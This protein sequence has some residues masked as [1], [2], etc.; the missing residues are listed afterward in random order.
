MRYCCKCISPLC[1]K[2]V[3]YYGMFTSICEL[4]LEENEPIEISMEYPENDKDY[5]EFLSTLIWLE[6]N[7]FI[8]TTES[9]QDLTKI[10]PQ[11]LRLNPD[12]ADLEFCKCVTIGQKR[13]HR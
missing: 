6:K 13:V 3:K 10:I 11:G 9:D 1:R 12:Y 4:W 7:G 2:G 8:L 5:L